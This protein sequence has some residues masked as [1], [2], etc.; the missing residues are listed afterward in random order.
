MKIIMENCDVVESLL[1]HIT[2]ILKELITKEDRNF[3]DNKK[4][5][6]I[7]DDLDSFN[8]TMQI[9]DLDMLR[10]TM[11]CSINN[12]NVEI[13]DNSS[14]EFKLLNLPNE[15]MEKEYSRL[16]NQFYHLKNLLEDNYNMSD[17]LLQY[18]HPNS[19]LMNVRLSLSVKELL[20]FML[21]CAK[22]DELLDINVLLSDV[23]ELMANLVTVAM[24]LNDLILAD[25]VFIRVIF[26]E[27]CRKSLLES[28]NVNIELMSNESYIA[29]CV[30]NNQVD[31]KMSTLGT[32]SLVAYRDMVN[33]TKG[34]KIE[35]LYNLITQEYVSLTLPIEYNDID[36][37]TMNAVDTYLYD[38]YVFFGNLKEYEE[39]EI[40]ALL[41]CLGCFTN[42][43]KMN[44]MIENYNNLLYSDLSEVVDL[45][46][47]VKQKIEN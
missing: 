26:E 38:W 25:D 47:V 9:H 13:I 44:T 43:F 18:I 2:Q 41:C 17:E 34:I 7:L 28:G 1:F 39:F 19:R 11:L 6:D 35:N 30:E 8:I 15:E 46:S 36:E 22:Y 10:Y 40:E 23:D 5:R 12:L 21:T 33:K 16:L 32:C 24:S 37:Y 3:D 42:I 14:W 4:I 20:S 29:Y 31:V 27:A 45:M